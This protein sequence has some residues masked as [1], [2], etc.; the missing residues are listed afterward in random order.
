MRKIKWDSDGSRINFYEEDG[1]WIT[2][3][4]NWELAQIA[5]SVQFD[6]QKYELMEA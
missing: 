1:T 2:S 6:K 3:Y 4:K 5:A